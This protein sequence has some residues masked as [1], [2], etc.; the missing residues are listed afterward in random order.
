MLLNL[1]NYGQ[2]LINQNEG[3]FKARLLKKEKSQY[4][5]G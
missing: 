4:K 2:M 1:I 5:I 3:Q